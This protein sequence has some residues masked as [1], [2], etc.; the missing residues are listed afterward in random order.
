VEM[1]QWMKKSCRL[2]FLGL[3]LKDRLPG[4]L[5]TERQEFMS[6]IEDERFREGRLLRRWFERMEGKRMESSVAAALQT[7]DP[8]VRTPAI[9]GI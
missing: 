4:P 5:G 9:V 2:S 6:I 3:P 8:E 7:D 1:V